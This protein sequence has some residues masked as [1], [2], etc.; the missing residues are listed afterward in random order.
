[1]AQVRWNGQEWTIEALS[2]RIA[3]KTGAALTAR[4]GSL[5]GNGSLDL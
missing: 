1:M 4:P 5:P 2:N 3:K